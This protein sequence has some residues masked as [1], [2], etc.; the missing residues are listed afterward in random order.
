MRPVTTRIDEALCDGCGLCVRVCPSDT[1][2]LEGGKAKVVGERSLWCGHCEAVCPK[3]AVKVEGLDPSVLELETLSSRVPPSL[4][5]AD[6][7]GLMKSRFSCRAYKDE[8]VSLDLLEDLVRIGTTA[9]TGTNSQKW[10]FTILPERGRVM[11]LGRLVAEFYEK[12]NRMARNPFLRA[13]SRLFAGGELGKYYREYYP[14]VQKALAEWRETGRDRLFHGAPAALVIGSLPGASCPG[15]DALLAAGW[16]TLAAH[17]MGL[18]TCLVGYAVEAAKREKRIRRWLGLRPGETVH[19]VLVLG[20]P[21]L[22]Y[23]GEKRRLKPLLR[24]MRGEN[25]EAER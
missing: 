21:A 19:A 12:V 22:A 25:G 10:T 7:A 13:Y 2:A 15:E 11:E 16:M 17:S 18:G 5:P 3:G 1:L 4:D 20:R 23:K 9:P 14:M 8:P 6:L 24:V